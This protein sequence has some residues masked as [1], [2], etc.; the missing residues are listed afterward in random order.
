MTKHSGKKVD[1]SDGITDALNLNEAAFEREYFPKGSFEEARE[2]GLVEVSDGKGNWRKAEPTARVTL[3]LSPTIRRRAESLDAYL[4]MGYQN[5]LKTA[6]LL[7]I[8]EL[9][10]KAFT[11]K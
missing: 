4:R 2:Q 9:E 5:V 10:E 7:G 6:M 8:K 11:A 1:N 3:N